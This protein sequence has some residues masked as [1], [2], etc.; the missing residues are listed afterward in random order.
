[1]MHWADLKARYKMVLA[2]VRDRAAG[3]KREKAE[4]PKRLTTQYDCNLKTVDTFIA[5]GKTYDKIPAGLTRPHACQPGHLA[6]TA[7]R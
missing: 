7:K 6:T 3:N 4:L 1:M 5:D 2:A